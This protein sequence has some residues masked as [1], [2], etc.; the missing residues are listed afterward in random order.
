MGWFK[1]I[2]YMWN[3]TVENAVVKEISKLYDKE[4]TMKMVFD[5][6]EEFFRKN[7]N[8]FSTWVIH[9]YDSQFDYTIKYYY[10]VLEE[11]Y[12]EKQEVKKF[13]WLKKE[14]VNKKGI[15]RYLHFN[16]V[17]II[18]KAKKV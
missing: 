9:T 6:D 18:K 16:V 11:E 13:L 12:N 10:I 7:F 15:N 4:K 8:K 3:I 17:N 14:I 1:P 5:I 2:H